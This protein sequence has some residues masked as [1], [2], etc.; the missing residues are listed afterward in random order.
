MVATV[1][2]SLFGVA[3]L[4]AAGVVLVFRRRTMGKAAAMGAAET[5]GAADAA[6]LAP[7]SVVEVKGTLRCEAPLQSEM[8]GETC[9][10]Y[11]ARVV[12][13]YIRDDHDDDDAGSDRRSETV[14]HNER[15]APFSVEDATGSI[16]VNAEEAEVDAKEVVDRFERHTGGRSVTVAGVSLNLGGGERTLGFRHVEEVLPVDAPVYV[17]GAVQQDGTI[18]AP[19]PGGE[20]RFV[21]SHR[22]EEALAR[23]FNKDARLLGLVAAG[24]AALG[25]VFLA[26]GVASAAGLIQFT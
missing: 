17:L 18:G 25:L 7:G 8:A 1:I 24:L 3:L 20:N 22:S 19:D 26:V 2:F 6:S 23:Q 15:F 21:V 12:R 10:Y 13:E 14:S 11:S 9:A 16:A 4:V 5:S